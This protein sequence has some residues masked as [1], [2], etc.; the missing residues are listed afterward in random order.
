MQNLGGAGGR[1]CNGLFMKCLTRG[2]PFGVLRR[3]GER[4]RGQEKVRNATKENHV[5][6]RPTKRQG[7]NEEGRQIR[8]GEKTS[9]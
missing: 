3:R 8:G 7:C 1:S 4:R 5:K 2:C 6:C 9:N